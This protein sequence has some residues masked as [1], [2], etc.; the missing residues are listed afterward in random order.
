MINY[1]TASVEWFAGRSSNG[2]LNIE[3]NF[4]HL[5]DETG[6]LAELLA[7]QHLLFNQNIFAMQVVIPEP[8][9][10]EV[11]DIRILGLVNCL[12][13]APL[14]SAS[15]FLRNRLKGVDL[16]LNIDVE[17]FTQ[18]DKSKS[19]TYIAKEPAERHFSHVV[20]NKGHFDGILINTHAIDKYSRLHTGGPLRKPISSLIARLHNPKLVK[21]DIPQYVL[22]HKLFKY[23]NNENIEVWG[24]SEATLRF[25][26]VKERQT[27][28]LR[29]VFHRPVRE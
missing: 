10:L 16:R 29:T 6:L 4:N 9:K 2:V 18:I 24:I 23:Y 14:Y 17:C 12:P 27:K 26:I 19:N 11:S 5:P 8:I 28:C 25:L 3:L 21:I 20:I 13:K 15:A 22:R 1:N 7:I